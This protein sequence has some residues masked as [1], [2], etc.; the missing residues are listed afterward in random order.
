MRTK[1]KRRLAEALVAHSTVPNLD[2]QT[3][4][5]DGAATTKTFTHPLYTPWLGEIG[6]DAEIL[7][8]GCGYGRTMEALEREGFSNLAGVDTS[9]GMIVRR[10]AG[11]TS[12]PNEAARSLNHRA[13]PSW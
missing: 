9:T 1:L 11:R 6:R 3:A 12:M 5:W 10:S 4:Y 2:T 8:Y 7:D 13:T